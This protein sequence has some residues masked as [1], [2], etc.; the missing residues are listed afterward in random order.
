M[1]DASADL[2]SR[3]LREQAL[4]AHHSGVPQFTH[5]LEPPDEI[6]ARTAANEA[7]THVFFFGGYPDAERRIAAFSDDPTDEAEYPIACLELKWNPKFASPEHRDLLGA[8]MGLGIERDATGDIAFGETEGTAYLF[9]RE[10]M[11]SYICAGLESAGRAHLSVSPAAQPPRLREPEGRTIRVTVSSERLDAI[12]AES[13][14]LSRAQAQKLV[15]Q[16][17]VKRNH[18]VELRGDVHLA[19]G[20]LLSV[21]GFGRMRILAFDGDTRRGRRIVRLFRFT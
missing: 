4:R 7:G 18:A 3:R 20:D 8:V 17:L 2:L 11:A 6:R 5:F 13:L 14:N 16:G 9:A 12:L 1:T 19:E 10:D 21:R 15:S